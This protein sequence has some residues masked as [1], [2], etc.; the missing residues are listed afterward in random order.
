MLEELKSEKIFYFFGQISEIP[1]GSYHNEKISEYLI[2]FAADRG[3]SYYAD[4]KKN[5]IIRK[6]GTKGYENAK[7]VILQAH[8]DMVCESDADSAGKHDFLTEPLDLYIDG[9][10]IK[11]KNT[12]LGADNGIGMAYILTILDGG[13][14]YKHPPLEALFTADEEVGMLGAAALDLTELKGK[15]LINLDTEEEGHLLAS[16]AGGISLNVSF[17]LKNKTLMEEIK[18]TERAV[19][20]SV[21]GLTG[22]HSGMDIDKNRTNAAIVLGRILF[23]LTDRCRLA[24]FKGGI[25]SNAITRE[26]EAVLLLEQDKKLWNSFC[27]NINHIIDELCTSEPDISIN[28]EAYTGELAVVGKDLTNRVLSFLNTVPQGVQVMSPDM[29]GLVESS[30]NMGSMRM[31]EDRVEMKF[32]LRSQ[33]AGYKEYL[34]RKIILL[35]EQFGGTCEREGDYPA[36]DYKKDSALRNVVSDT[37]REMYGNDMVL[38]GV[39]AGLECG[40]FSE[41]IKG[42][43]MISI[44]PDITDAHSPKERVSISSARRVFKLLTK[45]L[46]EMNLQFDSRYI[47]M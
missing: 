6:S 27:G 30:V 12:T 10:F 3:L 29:E 43:D 40:V 23:P 35:A 5:V 9:D 28:C 41:G 8:M 14:E 34:C 32:C 17:G 20:I 33:R 37:Y 16:C 36:W 2:Q 39:H 11:A 24:E 46:E 47:K 31:T 25:S 1:R 13:T 22:G 15:F 42:I 44:G 7:P 45:V 38:E 18:E 21:K 4:S 19:R 26:A